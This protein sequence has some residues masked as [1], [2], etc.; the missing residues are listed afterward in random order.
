CDEDGPPCKPCAALD[1]AC[2]FDRVSRRR[3]PPNR[4]A[5]ALKKRRLDPPG[6]SGQST[7][8]SPTHAAHTLASFAQQ[9]VLSA[10]SICPMPLLQLL[11][12]DYFTYV[13]PLIPIPH[14]PSF[15][16]ALQRREDLNN[17]TFL[18][19]LASMI[20]T[21]VASFPR[22][23]RLHLKAQHKGNMFPNS[24]SL[25]ERCHRITVE[26]RGPGYLLKELSV[27]DAVIS[28]LQGLTAANIFNFRQSNLYFGEC[29]N[30]SRSLGLHRQHNKHTPA[31]P[32]A[33][34][35]GVPPDAS[36]AKI[37]YISEEMGRRLFWVMFVGVRTMQILGG[38]FGELFIPPSTP[39]EPYPPL[40]TEVD[41]DYIYPSH[42]LPQPPGFI[43]ELVGFNANVR[44][45]C[46]C[47]S[48]F[49][50]EL[51][52]GVNE[53]FDW[54]KQNGVLDG[55]LR[56]VKSCFD[57][58]PRELMLRSGSRTGEFGSSLYSQDQEYEHPEYP[59]THSTTLHTGQESEESPSERRR[60]QC[61][62]QKANI[63]ASQLSTRSCIVE[64]YWNLRDA[65][66]ARQSPNTST[67]TS[68]DE[69]ANGLGYGIQP[70][71][72][73]DPTDQK[74]AMERENIVKELVA[75]LG[76][77][78]QANM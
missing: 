31:G 56:A 28:Y 36:D 13:H 5:E 8:T 24:M 76:M 50:I 65:C 27:Y 16:E 59:T 54:K 11:V 43:S 41:D 19:L 58:V 25:I 73:S 68:P 6:P 61:E 72:V 18:A 3:G 37:D 40:P 33:P 57:E 51:A 71:A 77:I 2:T 14:E 78:S 26:A 10:E 20:G 30:I 7:P 63:Y 64:K 34:H 47:N 39:S 23:P 35:I 44:V 4:H 17:L 49:A 32:L 62:I 52:F 9:Q 53:I 1:I 60:L 29:L 66:A 55:C 46:S 48:L 12:D 69:A 21:L 22:K 75:V 15:R 42:I 38:S 45:F 70:S 74:M 67:V